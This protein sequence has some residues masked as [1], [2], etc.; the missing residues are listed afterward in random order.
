MRLPFLAH[1]QEAVLFGYTLRLEPKKNAEEIR[2]RRE[3]SW[4]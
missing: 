3:K 2:W 4:Q 1:D